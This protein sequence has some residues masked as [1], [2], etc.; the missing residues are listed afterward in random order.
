VALVGLPQCLAYATMSGLPPAYGL[1]TAAVPGLAAALAGRSRNVITG[2][3]NTTGLFVLGALVPFLG[4]NGLLDPTGLSRL[5]TLTLLCGV[6]RLL[7]AYAGGSVFVRFIPESVLAGFIIGVA[8]LIVTMQ[9]DEALG[10]PPVSAAGLED[11]Y[12]GVANLVA[13]GARPSLAAIGV[14]LLC[15]GA[16]AAGGR[17]WRRFPAA[18][19][20]VLGAAFVA[21]LFQLDAS[22]GLPLVGDRTDVDAGWP[23]G[24]WPDLRPSVVGSLLLP[25]MAIVLLGTLELLVSVRA[26]ES[27]PAMRREIVAQGCANIAGA[28]ASAFPASASL[29][30]SALLRMGDPQSRA[31]AAFAALFSLPILVFGS[32]LTSYIP[33]AALAGVLFIA[34]ASMV[35]QPAFRRM[36]RASASSR[37][38]LAATAVSTLVLPLTWAVF[39]GAGL[40]LLMHLAR[41]ST[42]R[43]RALTFKNDRLVPIGPGENPAVVVLEISGVLYYAAVEP[44]LEQ[45]E[46]SLPSAARL[47]VVDLSHAHE[48]RFTGLRA[49]EWC[50]VEL[51]RRGIRMRL[52]GVTPDVR[53]ILDGSGSHL[54]YTMWDP[55][56]GRS[57]WNSYREGRTT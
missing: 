3:T 4:T 40:G 52:A 47:V 45:M 8:V 20:A 39:V 35:R 46:R 48:L 51:E 33:Q 5:A 2:P 17:R 31:A 43:V 14:T 19:L 37:L 12:A 9:L 36:W 18:L 42:P 15:V 44:L 1:A 34:A 11:E 16:V 24:A 38:L 32:H 21:W 49:L 55:E 6:L 30:R 23:P 50:A 53:D 7:F 41:T 26:D 10:L 27:R 29:T 25:S 56:P 13:A 57:A 22:V 54:P 28:F